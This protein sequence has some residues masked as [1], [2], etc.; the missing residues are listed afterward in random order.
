MKAICNLDVPVDSK[1]P[2]YSSPTEEVP[3]GKKPRARSRLKRKQS[4]K[5]T[6]ESTTKASKSQSGHSKK[7]T[8]S[9]SAMDISPSH[10]LPP[11][12]VVDEMH[13]E[14]QQASGGP[15]SLGANSE[16]GAHPQLSSG[17]DALANFIA[18]ANPEISAP[19]DSISYQQGMDEGTKNYSFAYILAGS[20]PSILVDKTKSVGDGLKT[21][22]TTSDTRSAF[23]TPDSLIDEPIIVLDESEEEED[24]EKDKD[25]EDTSVPPPMSLKSAQIQELM[26]QPSYPDINQLTELLVTSLKPEL[27]KLLASHDFASCLP[28]ALKELPSKITEISGEIKELKQHVRDIEIELHGDLLEIP[29]KLETFTSTISSL[30]SQL[31]TLDSLPSLLHK[32][33]NTLNRFSTMVDNASGATSMHVPSAGQAAALP[34]EGEK[35]TKFVGTNLKDELIDLSG[36][37][38]VTQ[39]YTKKLLFDK[40]CDKILRRKKTPNITNYEVLTKKGPITLKIYREDG[41]DEV[42]SN[43]K[44]RVDK[45]AQTEQELKIDLNQPLKEQDPLNELIDLANKKRKRTSDLRDHSSPSAS[46]AEV[47]SASALHVLRRLGSIFTSMYAAVQKLKKDSWLEIQFSL[48][49]NS[50]LNVVYLLNRS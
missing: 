26:D 49:D 11:I 31:Q 39:Y 35:N 7:E 1:A 24:A 27:S 18:E 14:A 16:E 44:T 8:K 50:K 21:G 29:T 15:T 10:P 17:H 42:V 41:S 45:L 22:H 46:V 28:T 47:P 38:V 3:Q 12:P 5:H 25:T 32:V 4:L 2:K 23:F 43:L 33:T 30:P 48:A 9:S 40:Y 19:K 6:Y 37:D 13:K 20:N 34:A 36:K